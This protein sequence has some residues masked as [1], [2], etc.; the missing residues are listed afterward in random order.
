MAEPSK[1]NNTLAKPSNLFFL[2]YSKLWKSD[3]LGSAKGRQSLQQFPRQIGLCL[4]KTSDE[5]VGV[6][7]VMRLDMIT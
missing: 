2:I 3:L 1:S 5:V 4:V 6:M 7:L